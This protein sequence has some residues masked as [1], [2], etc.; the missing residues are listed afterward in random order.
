MNCNCE[1]PNET[2]PDGHLCEW[3][4]PIY[5]HMDGCDSPGCLICHPEDAD[6]LDVRDALYWTEVAACCGRP[7]IV[8]HYHPC[9]IEPP[10]ATRVLD[11]AVN[12]DLDEIPF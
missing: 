5:D 10:P 8:C 6:K 1:G 9:V 12:Y 11:Q 2:Y 3:H 4:A 7:R